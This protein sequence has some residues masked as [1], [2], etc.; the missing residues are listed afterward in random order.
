MM[1]APPLRPA[2][3]ASGLVAPAAV[4]RLELRSGFA[5]LDLGRAPDGRRYASLAALITDGDAPVGLVVVPAPSGRVTPE[6]LSEAIERQVDRAAAPLAAVLDGPASSS[7]RMSVVVTT[8]N[9]PRPLMRAIDSILAAGGEAIEVIVVEN[10]PRGSTVAPALADRF[11]GDR[12]LR[13]VEEPSPGLSRAR[14]A[15][16]AACSRELIAFTDDDV[17][18]DERWTD[19]LVNGLA[20]LPD[21]AAVTG[22]ILPLQLE[23][24][25]QVALERY[26]TFG[27]G[28]RTI[29]FHADAPGDDPLFPYG[30]GAFGSGANAAF[31]ADALRAIGA[32]DPSLGAGTPARGGEDLDIFIRVLLAGQAILYEPS[33][34]VWHEH[35]RTPQR[36]RRQAFGYG[37]GLTAMLAKHLARGPDRMGIVRRVPAGLAHLVAPSSRKN[38]GKGRGYPRYLDAIE[39]AGMAVGPIG[40]ARSRRSPAPPCP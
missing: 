14:N 40:Y 20:A 38:Q 16:L 12:R 39:L 28:F 25:A 7:A 1:S 36:L 22:L 13:Y 11:P 37:M 34:I 19:R 18:V 30:A 4:R 31:R 3:D 8:C 21:A 29:V 23:T 33:A 26:A 24:D 9:S 5:P 10:R 15:G 2:T 6:A 17:V 32:F 27:K 35:P